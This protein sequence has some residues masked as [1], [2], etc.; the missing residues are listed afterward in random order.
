LI[1]DFI[2]AVNINSPSSRLAKT[3]RTATLWAVGTIIICFSFFWLFAIAFGPG[4]PAQGQTIEDFQ[5]KLENG[6]YTR[7]GFILLAEV[8]AYTLLVFIPHRWIVKSKW[9]FFPILTIQLAP[10]I[11]CTGL[12]IYGE[13]ASLFRGWSFLEILFNCVFYA[14]ILGGGSA[15]LS[16]APLSLWWSWKIRTS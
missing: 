3:F 4:E 5:Q 6:Y 16:F 15:L 8:W 11:A 9:R 14:V 2:F 1:Q 7:Q 10:A 13:V 12:L